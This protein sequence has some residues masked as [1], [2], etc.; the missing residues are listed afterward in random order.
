MGKCRGRKI[1]GEVERKKKIK[2]N[3]NIVKYNILLLFVISNIF[4]LF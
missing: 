1:K 4:D 3:T 2:I